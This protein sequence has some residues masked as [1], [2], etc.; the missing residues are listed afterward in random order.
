MAGNTVLTMGSFDMYHVGHV[1]L[2]R[3]CRKIAGPEGKVIVGINSDEFMTEFKKAP[4][5]PFSDRQEVVSSC[6]YVDE[7][8]KT[9]Q[10]DAKPNILAIN[11]DFIVIGT[12]WI[13][14]GK[15]YHEQLRTTKEFL[16]ENNIVLLYVERE[17]EW[18]TTRIR[19]EV[20]DAR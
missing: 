13:E 3:T 6:V 7:V 19:N 11:P 5:I 12:D 8:F 9:T 16:I 15:D 4:I 14:N 2:L 18:S 20:Q 17:T 10:H 1:S